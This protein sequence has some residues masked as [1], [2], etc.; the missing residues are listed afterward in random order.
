MINE[1]LEAIEEYGGP[2]EINRKAKEAGKL[3]NLLAGLKKAKSPYLADLNWLRDQKDKGAFI[4]LDAYYQR[5]LG[6]KAK[7]TRLDPL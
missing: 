7:S 6:K 2:Q 5:V 4:S 1:L 3:E